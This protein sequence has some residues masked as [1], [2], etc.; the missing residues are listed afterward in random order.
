MLSIRTEYSASTDSDAE[1][2]T[3]KTH[4]IYNIDTR[5]EDVV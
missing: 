1:E 3:S 2:Y 5:N 4:H